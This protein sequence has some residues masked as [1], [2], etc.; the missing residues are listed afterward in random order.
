MRLAVLLA[1]VVLIAAGNALSVTSVGRPRKPLTGGVAA[2][3]V[4]VNGLLICAVVY[5]YWSGR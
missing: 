5:L 4:T 1:V 3:V 2:A